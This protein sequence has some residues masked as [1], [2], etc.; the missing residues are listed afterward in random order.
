MQ[1]ADGSFPGIKF[2]VN[3]KHNT[4]ATSTYEALLAM[5]AFERV[6]K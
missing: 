2:D 6:A 3:L 1:G 4:D 5:S